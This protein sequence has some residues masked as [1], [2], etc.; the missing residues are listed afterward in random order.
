[1]C[2]VCANILLL[3]MSAEKRCTSPHPEQRPAKLQ[4]S[5]HPQGSSTDLSEEWYDPDLDQFPVR[6]PR[7]LLY[8]MLVALY[9]QYWGKGLASLKSNGPFVHLPLLDNVTHG[10]VYLFKQYE[11]MEEHVGAFREN[12]AKGGPAEAPLLPGVALL[13]NPGIGKLVQTCD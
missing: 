1:M 8:Q 5:A 13:G 3:T 10:R 4:A 6:P 12:W 2:D 9:D 11:Y 7:S